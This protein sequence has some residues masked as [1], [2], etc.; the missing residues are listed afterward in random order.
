MDNPNNKKRLK[1]I[2]A[3]LGKYN[4]TSRI[5]PENLTALLEELGPTFVKLGQIMSMQPTILPA[6]YCK[7]L[8][9]LR[10]SVAPMG[11]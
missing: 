1:E 5:T 2:I 4:I 3:I 9:K 10:T 7:E 6:Q 8:E 11:F